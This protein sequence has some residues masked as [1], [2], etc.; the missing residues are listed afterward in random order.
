MRRPFLKSREIAPELIE[1]N[2]QL[3]AFAGQLGSHFCLLEQQP[4]GPNGTPLS[5][6]RIGFKNLSDRLLVVQSISK[7]HRRRNLGNHPGS[8]NFIHLISPLDSNLQDPLLAEEVS[9]KTAKIEWAAP[10]QIA[11]I[12]EHLPPATDRDKRYAEVMDFMS[13]LPFLGAF[14]EAQPGDLDPFVD[15]ALGLN[16]MSARR[17]EAQSAADQQSGLVVT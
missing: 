13:R 2:R 6:K 4:P 14:K 8:Y 16:E 15:V 12:R 3:V 10:P 11:N 5:Q 7:P 1:D 17:M 9:I